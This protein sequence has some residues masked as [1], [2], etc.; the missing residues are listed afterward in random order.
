VFFTIEP[1]SVI[2]VKGDV[3]PS[4]FVDVLSEGQIV[5]VFMRDISLRGDRI[6]QHTANGTLSP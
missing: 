2:T 1:G 4:G 3:Q 5:S 6:K